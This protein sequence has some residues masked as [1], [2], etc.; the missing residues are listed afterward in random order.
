M[1]SWGMKEGVVGSR[2]YCNQVPADG[3]TCEEGG[4]RQLDGSK[5]LHNTVHMTHTLE[6]G[7]DQTLVDAQMVALD[8]LTNVQVFDL[9]QYRPEKVLQQVWENLREQ[10]AAGHPRAHFVRNNLRIV[11]CGGDGTIGWLMKTVKQLELDP[12]PP[13]AI[14]PLGTGVI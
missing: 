7:L 8:M 2:C 1:D 13:I 12:P 14:I 6:T 4:G 5:A 9:A 3:T 11:V 10:E